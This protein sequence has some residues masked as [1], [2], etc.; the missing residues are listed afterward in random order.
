MEERRLQVRWKEPPLAFPR[1]AVT[2]VAVSQN[3]CVASVHDILQKVHRYYD[4][5]SFVH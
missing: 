4:S 5:G 2:E 1:Q 3:S